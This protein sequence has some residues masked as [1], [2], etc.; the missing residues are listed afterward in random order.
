M[1]VTVDFEAKNRAKPKRGARGGPAVTGFDRYALNTERKNGQIALAWW[2]GIMAAICLPWW[3]FESLLPFAIG[4]PLWC[5]FSALG[6]LYVAPGMRAAKLRKSGKSAVIGNQNQAPI[7][8]LI[9]KASKIYGIAEPDAFIETPAVPVVKPPK[10]PPKPKPAPKAPPKPQIEGELPTGLRGVIRDAAQALRDRE[11]VEK[12]EQIIVN[13]GAA[14]V[15]TAPTAIFL[16]KD[17]FENLDP[18]EISALVVSALVHLRQGHARR[19]FLLDFVQGTSQKTTLALVWPVLIYARLLEALWVPHAQQNADRLA[20]FLV[21]NPNLMLSAILKDYAARDVKM[22]EIGVT[23][24]DVSN[25]INQRG[26]IGSSGE[27]ISTQYKLGRA[28]HEDPPLEARLQRLQNWSKSPEF[29]A[30]VEEL[31]AAKR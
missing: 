22:Q 20:L 11:K 9:G 18:N 3:K 7:K 15:Q 13:L 16:H 31:K 10:A 25:W 4:M 12:P 28:I 17:A 19:L 21:K 30:A 14:S 27:E 5:L 2:I 8:D 26:H 29:A 6:V 24:H 23:S 1:A